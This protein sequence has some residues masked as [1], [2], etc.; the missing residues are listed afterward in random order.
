MGLDIDVYE[1]AKFVKEWS[2]YD[3]TDEDGMVFVSNKAFPKRLGEMKEGIYSADRTSL[4]FRAG[5]YGGYGQWRR[6]L[7]RLIYG[8]EIEEWWKTPVAESS[9]PFAEL[10]NMA[11]NE[12]DIGTSVC[13]KLARDFQD[14]N[15]QIKSVG[16][17]YWRELAYNWQEA[18]KRAGRCN[19]FVSFG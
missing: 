12:G 1:N 3:D 8:I 13:A 4:G 16:D 19:G 15:E 11:D 17:E 10:L 2:S 9:Q 7:C 18:F 14:H 5:S 6:Q